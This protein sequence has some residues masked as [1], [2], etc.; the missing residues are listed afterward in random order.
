[1]ARLIS[2][3]R[4]GIASLVKNHVRKVGRLDK[5]PRRDYLS[6]CSVF[7]SKN[8]AEAGSKSMASWRSALESM[9][10]GRVRV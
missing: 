4:F 3:C 2:G 5:S 7:A 8:S 6:R 1:M 9:F 10:I